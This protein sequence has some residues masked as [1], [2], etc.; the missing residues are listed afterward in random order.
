M[1]ARGWYKIAITQLSVNP[2]R[3]VGRNE[4]GQAEAFRDEGHDGRLTLELTCLREVDQLDSVRAIETA[5][6]EIGFMPE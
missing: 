1:D 2:S 6:Q 5:L 4:F 3:C